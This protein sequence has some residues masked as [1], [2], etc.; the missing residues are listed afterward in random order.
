MTGRLTIHY[1]QPTPLHTPLRLEGVLANVDGR[2]ILTTGRMTTPD[3]TLT[4]EA[5]GL[6]ISIDFAKFAELKARREAAA[7]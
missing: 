6:F 7:G 4:A 1:R 5:E 2:K 3:G